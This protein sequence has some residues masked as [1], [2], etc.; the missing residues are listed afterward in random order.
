MIED[1]KVHLQILDEVT[2][3]LLNSVTYEMS[4]VDAGLYVANMPV[5]INSIVKYRY[6]LGDSQTNIEFTP[7][8]QPV[9]YRM[10]YAYQEMVIEDTVST[11]TGEFTGNYGRVSG[12]VVDENGIPE[13][14]SHWLVGMDIIFPAVMIENYFSGLIWDNFMRNFYVQFA[15][16]KAFPSYY[17]HLAKK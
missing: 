11:W 5:P 3:L 14:N 13:V 8:G 16:L 4:R 12:I 10:M 9:R 15:L 2:G 17:L 6:T 1:E 7:M